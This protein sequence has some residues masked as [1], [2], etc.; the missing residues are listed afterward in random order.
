MAGN[1]AIK[2]TAVPG[3]PGFHVSLD[4][5]IRGPSG[6]SL[7]PMVSDSGHLYVLYRRDGV[8]KKLYVH[9]AVLMT[10]LGPCP[11]GMEGRHLDG[12]PAN[13]CLFNLDWGTRREQRQ[14]D[15][16]NGVVRRPKDLTLNGTSVGVILRAKGKTSA[17]VIGRCY[18]VSHTTILKIWRGERWQLIPR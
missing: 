2:W 1:T 6:R 17:R 12:N 8:Q 5:A 3:W 4:G 7:S 9:R 18:G 14:D 13:C 15:R 11:P 10:Y 16:R